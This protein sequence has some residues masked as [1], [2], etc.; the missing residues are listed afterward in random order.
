MKTKTK[1]SVIAGVAIS[2]MS[3]V[4]V[5]ETPSK[6]LVDLTDAPSIQTGVS[7]LTKE[8]D[9]EL[10]VLTSLDGKAQELDEVILLACR[11]SVCPV[12]TRH[13]E[14][15]R[16]LLEKLLDWFNV[17]PNSDTMIAL[18]QKKTDKEFS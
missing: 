17:G 1:I 3:S 6:E 13:K 14:K 8:Q 18:T 10:K 12:P 5:A 15:E 9:A 2:T 16:T 7:N 11:E 4:S